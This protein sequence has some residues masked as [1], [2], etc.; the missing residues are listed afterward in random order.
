MRRNIK[1]NGKSKMAKRDRKGREKSYGNIMKWLWENGQQGEIDIETTEKNLIE[2]NYQRKKKKWK[3]ESLEK[4]KAEFLVGFVVSNWSSLSI[5][6][7]IFKK[8]NL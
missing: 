4:R 3:H 7:N 5:K 1:S 8:L 2:K 6:G